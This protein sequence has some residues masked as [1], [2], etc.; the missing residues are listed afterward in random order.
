M[1]ALGYVQAGG[2]STRFG[3]DKALVKLGGQTMLE[4]SCALLQEAIGNATIVVGAVRYEFPT[5]RHIEDRWPGEGPLGG[6]IT[7]LE[8]AKQQSQR[9]EWALIVS[10]DMPFLTTAWLKHIVELAEKSDA[11]AIVPR[12]DSGLEPLCACWR[13]ASTEQLQTAFGAGV[14]K[15][16]EALQRVRM[17]VLDEP[18]WKR[19]DTAGRL[20]WNMNTPAD[21]EEIRKAWDAHKS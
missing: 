9:G 4:R 10:C 3:Q 15:I 20:F 18:E 7:A 13:I 16:G 5:A 6:I 19:F 17:E 11:D 12:S 1:K 14:R 8:D 21:F 2:A